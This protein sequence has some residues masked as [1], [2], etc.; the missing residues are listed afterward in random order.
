MRAAAF[1]SVA[2][3]VIG[4][5]LLIASTLAFPPTWIALGML[6]IALSVAVTLV[7]TD[8]RAVPSR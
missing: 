7:G 5:F 6:A 4:A 3:I 2:V 8:G 1:T